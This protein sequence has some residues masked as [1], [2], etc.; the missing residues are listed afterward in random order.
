MSLILRGLMQLAIKLSLLQINNRVKI[1]F[2]WLIKYFLKFE[3]PNIEKVLT[4]K[5]Q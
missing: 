2:L 1:D 4:Y 5:K 3:N